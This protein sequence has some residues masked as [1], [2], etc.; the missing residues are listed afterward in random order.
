M[1]N[2]TI[3]S[4]FDWKLQKPYYY[5]AKKYIN[6]IECIH[7]GLLFPDLIFEKAHKDHIIP[8]ADLSLK[9][10]HAQ[11]IAMTQRIVIPMFMDV[12][13]ASVPQDKDNGI[14]CVY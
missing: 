13:K 7:W 8:I 1:R 2:I 5:T 4:F 6:G 3:Y 10:A 12:L 9:E 11:A 14:C